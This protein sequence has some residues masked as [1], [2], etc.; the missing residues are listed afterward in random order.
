LLNRHARILGTSVG[1]H[2]CVDL[3]RLN[4]DGVSKLS[5]GQCSTLIRGIAIKCPSADLPPQPRQSCPRK[6]DHCDEITAQG[7]DRQIINTTSTL[8][9]RATGLRKCLGEKRIYHAVDHVN[10]GRVFMPTSAHEGLLRTVD[11]PMSYFL[12]PLCLPALLLPYGG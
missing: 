8:K 4:G 5:W 12:V 3:K 2:I 6:R 9:A 11:L 7:L 10:R 1:N